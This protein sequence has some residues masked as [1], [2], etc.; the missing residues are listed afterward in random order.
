MAEA[1]VSSYE[2]SIVIYEADDKKVANATGEMRQDVNLFHQLPN[3]ENGNQ[4]VTMLKNCTQVHVGPK[5]EIHTEGPKVEISRDGPKIEIRTEEP[6]TKD[7]KKEDKEK[8]ETINNCYQKLKYKY[9]TECS[10]MRSFLWEGERLDFPL[11]DYFVELTVEKADLFG[12]KIGDNIN[13]NEL[14][15]IQEDGHQTILV[16]G[17]P[18]Y[19]K[20]TLCKK[21]AYDWASTNYLQHFDLTLLLILRELGNKSV[22]DALLHNMNEHS[23]TDK[24]RKLE[25]RQLNILV[26]LDGFDEVVE[27]NKVIKF[28]RDDSFDI[29]SRMTIVVT[30][31][32][33][34]AEDI[35]QNMKMRFSLEGFNAEYQE[36]YIQLMFGKDESKTNELISKLEEEEF[37]REVAECPLMLHM[38]C[39]LHKNG[40]MGKLE[41]MTDLYIRIFS[42]ITERYVRKSVQKSK[43]KTG[44]YFVGENLLL[45]LGKLNRKPCCITSKVLEKK[46]SNEDKYK[47]IIG[48]GILT[49]DSLS[50]CDNI[51]RYSFVHRTFG[52]FLSAL[53]IYMG[54]VPFPS[55]IYSAELLFLLG[56]YKHDPLPKGLLKAIE[57]KI[58]TPEFMLQVHQ[59]IE[60]QTNWE[61]F[62]SHSSVYCFSSNFSNFEQLLT[63]YQFKEFY[64]YFSES[65]DEYHELKE[66]LS[67]FLNNYC[68]PNNV[69]IYL[70]LFLEEIAVINLHDIREPVTYIIDFIYTINPN[71]FHIHFIGV[72]FPSSDSYEKFTNVNYNLNLSV[73]MQQ[74]L[75]VS[76]DEELVALESIDVLEDS[77]SYILSLQQYEALRHHI[78]YRHH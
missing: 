16:T 39:C 54:Y 29:S 3:V 1:A 18:G 37:Y 55:H 49:L 78:K 43:F 51:I 11:E 6:K 70:V 12:M 40:E 44:K 32:P 64:L 7:L 53:S 31:R 75:N 30:S 68:L 67:D 57:D 66:V 42:L 73:D 41:T 4:Y 63:L 34:A 76:E 62:C 38:L 56:F 60:L 71:N 17:N 45:K 25:D 48:L 36:V 59:Q 74:L 8:E 20:T 72:D 46:F 5:I 21:I 77:N 9:I 28:I 50:E 33:Q 2:K 27:R 52:E 47:F 22:K 14:F 19:G 13:L 24:V 15:S 65:M 61:Q 23:S 69:T 26:I 35:R 58:F 10:Y